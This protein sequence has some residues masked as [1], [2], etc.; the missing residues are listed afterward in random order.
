LAN[1]LL[2]QP[3][4]KML[5]KVAFMIRSIGSISSICAAGLAGMGMALAQQ[6][7]APGAVSPKP[8]AFDVVSMRENKTPPGPRPMLDI[9]PTADG[10]HA[11]NVP[12]LFPM[13]TA[14]VPTAP[15]GAT[16]TPNQISG[17]PD[18]IM[19]EQYD[20]SAKV[21]E[22]EMA[23]WQKPGAQPAMLREMLQTMFA[24]RCKI[25]VHRE[26][27]ES[28]VSFLVV[29]KN[30]PKFKETNPAETHAGMNIPFGGGGVMVPGP[31]GMHAY[32]VTMGTLA[33]FLSSMS[34]GTQTV[35]DKTGLTA[36]YDVLLKTPETA[37]P[38]FDRETMVPDQLSE[39]GLK[40]ESG[41]APVETL[42]IDHME[43][44]SAN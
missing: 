3:N 16:F 19:Q 21:G 41:K 38:G 34:G 7:A 25:V 22:A 18:W 4:S 15:A 42:V 13:L 2:R 36:K 43:R 35:V 39:L 29:G 37:G 17:L 32:G 6:P 8:L 1:R 33:M 5:R 10:Y 26:T 20:I 12:L 28:P 31:D 11:I 23:E 27:K 24:E 44:P 14:Y 9:G 30:G 40:L